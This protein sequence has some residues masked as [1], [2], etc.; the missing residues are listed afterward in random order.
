MAADQETGSE[1]AY[2]LLMCTQ[3][4]DLLL[5]SECSLSFFSCPWADFGFLLGC[6]GQPLHHFEAPW[7]AMEV[8]L[9]CLNDIVDF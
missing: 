6:F 9:V 2:I 8:A 7:V 3:F 1:T 5:S 4:G